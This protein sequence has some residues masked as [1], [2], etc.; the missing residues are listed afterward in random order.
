MPHLL[1]KTRAGA[2]DPVDRAS[3]V[4]FG[5]LMAMTLVG[6]IGVAESGREELRTLLVAAL[7]CNLAWGITDGVMYLVGLA[8][9]ERR[10]RA[11]LQHLHAGADAATGRRIVAEELLPDVAA[12]LD[13][14]DLERIRARLIAA[15][16]PAGTARLGLENYR[17]A[18]G[19]FLLVVVATFPVVLP[20]VFIDDVVRALRV[21]QAI[22]IATLFLAGAAL[23]RYSGGS[24]WRIGLLVAAVGALL[25]V[26]LIVLGG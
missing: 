20:Y 13:D 14:D 5:V 8:T 26:V 4:I 9:E 18:L 2:L 24:T 25:L 21:S 3:E 6:W 1:R 15:G 7:G 22:S 11:L 12:S 10:Y 17:A 23:A 19:I 16:P